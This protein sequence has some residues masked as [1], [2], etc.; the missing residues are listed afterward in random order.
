[1][2]ASTVVVVESGADPAEAVAGQVTGRVFR[3]YDADGVYAA[4]ASGNRVAEVGLAGVTVTAY[5]G[6]GTSVGTTT[7]ASGGGYTLSGLGNN[8]ALR[9]EFTGYPA[10]FTDSTR[11]GTATAT[12]TAN[13]SNTSV[14]FVSTGTNGASEVNLGLHKETDLAKSTATP[15]ITAVQA[16]GTYNGNSSGASAI[17]Y[18]TRAAATN[19]AATTAASTVATFSQVGATWGVAMQA[20]PRTSSTANEGYYVY[21]SA[22]VKRHSGLGPA[23]LAGL[24]RMSVTANSTTGAR[25]GTGTATVERINLAGTGMPSYGTFTRT[26]AD[27]NSSNT[28]TGQAPDS[29]AFAAAGTQ[30][31]GGIA[32]DDGYLYVVNLYDRNVYRYAL[33]TLAFSTNA[34]IPT[35]SAAPTLISTGLAS[36]ER[37][38]AISVHQGRIYLGVANENGLTARVLSLPVGSTSGWTQELSFSLGYQR[39]I[40]WSTAAPTTGQTQAQWHAWESNPATLYTASNLGSTWTTWQLSAYGQAILSG[41]D[42]DDGGNMLIGLADR[43]SLQS[44]EKDPWPNQTNLVVATPV[45]DTLY[46]GVS[47]TGAFSLENGAS[48]AGAT[49][50]TLLTV[51][52]AGNEAAARQPGYGGTVA[53]TSEQWTRRNIQH[54]GREFFEDSLRY[55]GAG[56]IDGQGVVHDETTLGAVAALPGIAQV[57]T[58]SYDAATS[59]NSA[60]NR[61]L[62][63][64]DGHGIDGFNQYTQNDMYFGKGGGIGGVA[65]LLSDAPVEIGNRAWYDADADG[66]Q[67]ADEPALNGLTVQ[68][69][70]ADSSG[71]PVSQVGAS[72]TTATVNGQA[73]TYYFRS[74][75][76]ATDPTT[77]FTKNGDYVVKFVK[78]TTGSPT[79]VWPGT[80]PT[81][82]STTPTWA[83]LELTTRTAGSNDLIDSNPDPV[84]GNAPVTVGD[85]GDDDHSIDAGYVALRTYTITKTIAAGTAPPGAQ[86]TID[87]SSATNFRGDDVLSP[88]NSTTDASRVTVETTSYTLA[89]GQT[90]TTTERIPYGYTLRFTEAGIPGAA[91]AFSPNI[92]TSDDTGQLVLSASA[93]ALTV[94]NSYTT[95]TV[96]KALSPTVTLPGGTTFPIEYTLDGGSTQSTTVAVGTPLTLSVPYATVVK[97]RE[98][99]VG[100]FS[101]GGWAWG[102]GTWT[103]GATSLT[104]D[105]NGWVTVTANSST[106]AVALTLTNHPYVPP[107]LPFAGGPASDL[108]TIGGALVL[109]IGLGLGTWQLLRRRRQGTRAAHRA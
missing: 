86:F 62:D 4:T 40:A 7:T 63:L 13:T 6:A 19:T 98:P 34:T 84:T 50:P 90:L 49:A 36:G 20:L 46:A 27:L 73:G 107:A 43:F 76:A 99:L 52:T 67:D 87:V 51:M 44:G 102:T 33:S 94:A 82:F 28:D 106:A 37:P 23:G 32:Y 100:P 69:W 91:V 39:G 24:Y 103:N 83:Q 74:Q 59:Y 92:G 18:I 25:V 71:N 31:I 105:A 93:G 101:W 26:T 64:T 10:G 15:I 45:G 75:D 2:L 53:T 85:F 95:V 38:W 109:A 30:G 29:G 9:I 58:S 60:G 81:A 42:F 72:K 8:T 66:I 68:L 21:A 56:G 14:Q 35:P 80:T 96:T 11:G 48:Q 1:M 89:A 88:T 78:P 5:N 3:D 41:L 16:V 97:L 65:V 57:V 79:Y 47:S 77:G 104:P 17:T 54:G 12:T 70:T 22:V 61:F 55:D 108:F